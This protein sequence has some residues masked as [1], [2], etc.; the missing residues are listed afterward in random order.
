VRLIGAVFANAAALLATTVVPGIDFE[1]SLLRLLFA[2]AVLGLFNLLVR[3]LA[4]LLSIPALILT[5]G[6]FYFVLNGLLLW[7]A[8]FVLPG[9]SVD[10]FVP[11]LLG[12]MVMGIVNWAFSVLFRREDKEE[13]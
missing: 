1:G 4:V 10:G 13:D 11:A 5:L 7:G 8:S 12:G 2:G 9:Y 3:P 6:V